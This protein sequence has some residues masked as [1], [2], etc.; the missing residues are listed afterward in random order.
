MVLSSSSAEAGLPEFE[1][2]GWNGLFAPKGTPPAVI[3]KLHD[4]FHK[5]MFSERHQQALARYDQ[6]LDYLN[7]RD[8]RQAVL[9]TVEREKKLL[10]RMNL[11]AAPNR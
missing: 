4:A 1:A 6:S 10:A 5:A 7:T 3:Q 9:D 8:Y 2:Q 11:L